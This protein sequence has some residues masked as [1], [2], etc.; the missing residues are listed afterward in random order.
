MHRFDALM[1]SH[2]GGPFLA[3]VGLK[4]ETF[5]GLPALVLGLRDCQQPGARRRVPPVRPAPRQ[6]PA[7]CWMP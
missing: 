5:A 1:R 7:Q 2:T 6:R 3:D 4:W